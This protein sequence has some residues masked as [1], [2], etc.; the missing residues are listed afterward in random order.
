MRVV[1]V[2]DNDNQRRVISNPTRHTA[3]GENNIHYFATDA[4]LARR[5]QHRAMTGSIYGHP[6]DRG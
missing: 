5:Q 4:R 2:I 3:S 1:M 6:T